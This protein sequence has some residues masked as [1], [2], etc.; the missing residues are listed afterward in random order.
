MN[1]YFLSDN[2]GFLLNSERSGW[3]NIYWHKPDGSV[4]NLTPGERSTS[5]VDFVDDQG[6]VYFGYS[7]G[8]N[9]YYGR[10]NLKRP[11]I[12]PLVTGAGTHFVRFNAEEG[13]FSDR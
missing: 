8:I 12:E 7:E 13:N 10:S 1:M 2:Q 4:V 3:N 9:R 6:N 11:G 5:N